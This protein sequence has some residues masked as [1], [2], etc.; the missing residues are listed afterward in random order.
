MSATSYYCTRYWYHLVVGQLLP[1]TIMRVIFFL[2][3][4]TALFTKK[5]KI[6]QRLR[7]MK[8][9]TYVFI[10]S[11]SSPMGSSASISTVNASTLTLS[12]TLNTTSM[13]CS[14]RR[15][16]AK[17]VSCA[18]AQQPNCRWMSVRRN[19]CAQSVMDTGAAKQE[20]QQHQQQLPL[21]SRLSETDSSSQRR[22]SP[23]SKSAVGLELP[24]KL[25]RRL[26]SNLEGETGSS[27]TEGGDHY[28]SCPTGVEVLL[29]EFTEASTLTPTAS[30]NAAIPTR[31][32]RS[33]TQD[34]SPK[35]PRRSWILLESVTPDA[36]TSKAGC[37]LSIANAA[38][39]AATIST[40][41][42]IDTVLDLSLP[43]RLPLR[44]ASFNEEE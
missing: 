18:F 33:T 39:A 3:I 1:L 10:P 40:E 17:S 30:V 6:R 14:S 43:T 23:P 16:R 36:E 44:K 42:T 19:N 8:V 27:S 41:K 28:G 29:S 15:P 4:D 20:H 7:R 26:A 31:L 21:K 25:P 32:D 11:F 22:D 13:K 24:P 38:A 37:P 5:G 34:S 2:N 35:I 9:P 12:P